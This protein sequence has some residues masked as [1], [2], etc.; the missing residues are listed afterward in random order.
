M[1]QIFVLIALL[2]LV[3]HSLFRNQAVEYK[4]VHI[5][6]QKGILVMDL[7]IPKLVKHAIL[8]ALLVLRIIKLA[9]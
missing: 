4:H 9:I 7:Q 3:F 1:I 8:D 6:A 5:H 2:M